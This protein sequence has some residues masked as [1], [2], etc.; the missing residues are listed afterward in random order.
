M[1]DTGNISPGPIFGCERYGS[2][3]FEL[4]GNSL[5][6][7]V[8]MNGTVKTGPY[9]ESLSRSAQMEFGPLKPGSSAFYRPE[10]FC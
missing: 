4:S 8:E 9:T 7:G 2:W 10:Y 1:Y 5:E 6:V 3:S